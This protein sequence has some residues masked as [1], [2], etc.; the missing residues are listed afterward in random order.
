MAAVVMVAVIPG[1]GMGRRAA[2]VVAVAV[3][4]VV[5]AW[6]RARV[7]PWMWRRRVLVFSSQTGIGDDHEPGVDDAGDPAEDCQDD[8]EDEGAGAAFAHEDCEGREE[9]C[10]YCFAAADLFWEWIC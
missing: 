9:D 4:A 8:V 2:V 1:V 7:R 6:V 3:V 5:S 10:D